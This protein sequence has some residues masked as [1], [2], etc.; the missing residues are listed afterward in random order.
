[1]CIAVLSTDPEQLPVPNV[2]VLGPYAIRV[3]WREPAIPNGNVTHYFIDVR[4]QRNVS[5]TLVDAHARFELNVTS[6]RPYI[7]Y[8]VTVKA[9]TAGGCG[10]SPVVQVRT[11]AAAP[12]GQPAPTAVAETATSLRVRWDPPVRANG[13]IVGYALYRSTLDEPVSS[14]FTGPTEYVLVFESGALQRDYLDVGLGIFSEHK[15]KVC[16]HISIL[17]TCRYCCHGSL[18]TEKTIVPASCGLYP[19]IGSI[20]VTK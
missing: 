7:R 10:T 17:V 16:L 18:T 4:D 20:T 2:L 19:P 14:N 6:L 8:D 12:E 11:L 9:C 13:A 5:S 15:Y 1:M 3:Q